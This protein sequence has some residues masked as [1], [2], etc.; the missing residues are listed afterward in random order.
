M[1]KMT[2]VILAVLCC[3]MFSIQV[4]ARPLKRFDPGT[5]TCR[6][7]TFKGNWAGYKTFANN[8]KTCHYRNNDKGA[9]FLFTESKTPKGW[10]R[11]FAKKYPACA[12]DGSWGELTLKDQLYLN[13]YLFTNG[14]GTYDANTDC[15]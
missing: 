13:D 4:E 14:L 2:V 15:G 5:R 10:N 7:F 8:C 9:P 6:V 11:V 3:W 1:K 12:K